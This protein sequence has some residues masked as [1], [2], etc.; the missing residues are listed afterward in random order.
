MAQTPNSRTRAVVEQPSRLP[1]VLWPSRRKVKRDTSPE[2]Q[3]TSGSRDG[4]PTNLA[5]LPKCASW[6]LQL[7]AYLG[8][9][10]WDL[11]FRRHKTAPSTMP[12][13]K[14]PTLIICAGVINPALR[15]AA[16]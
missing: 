6:N 16:V 7:G 8:F 10:I 11:G 3:W 13:I 1:P 2:G 5:R 15:C 14:I 12:A 4:C 9:G